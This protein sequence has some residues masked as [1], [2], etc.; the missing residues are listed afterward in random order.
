MACQKAAAQEFGITW[1]RQYPD[2]RLGLSPLPSL[3]AYFPIYPLLLRVSLQKTM[4]SPSQIKPTSERKGILFAKCFNCQHQ[5]EWLIHAWLSSWESSER[6]VVPVD[7]RSSFQRCLK[8]SM[9]YHA[10]W[11]LG[12]RFLTMCLSHWQVKEDRSPI[13]WLSCKSTIHLFWG[14]GCCRRLW[15]TIAMYIHH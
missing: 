5:D 2:C 11:N 15:R 8:A 7:A 6:I 13:K 14:L 1:G 3:S 10:I 9:G 12:H 4:S